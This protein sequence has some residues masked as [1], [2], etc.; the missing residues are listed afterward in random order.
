MGILFLFLYILFKFIP[1]TILFLDYK[2]EKKE[3]KKDISLNK[4]LNNFHKALNILG[5]GLLICSLLMPFYQKYLLLIILFELLVIWY[6]LWLSDKRVYIGKATIYL[7]GKHYRLKKIN[8]ASY[9][10]KILIF[11]LEN[12]IIKMKRPQLTDEYIQR[13]LIK[14]LSKRNNQKRK[15]Q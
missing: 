2:L 10:N 11:H 3:K 5:Y 8:N 15:K 1:V 6:Y 13:N 4:E 9:N 7:R 14:E 12:E